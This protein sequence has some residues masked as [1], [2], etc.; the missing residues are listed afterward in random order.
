MSAAGLVS[1]WPLTKDVRRGI[2]QGEQRER[3]FDPA[4]PVPNGRTWMVMCGAPASST[5]LRSCSRITDRL[6][7]TRRR[8][9]LWTP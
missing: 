2:G 8:T 5:S 3:S 9:S 4:A 1:V 7:T 6:P